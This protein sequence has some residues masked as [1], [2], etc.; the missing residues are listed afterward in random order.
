MNS[1]DSERVGAFFG[2]K[3]H[4][5]QRAIRSNVLCH[6]EMFATLDRVLADRVGNSNFRFADFGCGD[7]SAV[8]DV[9]RNKP[10]ARYIGVD[11]APDLIST[12]EKTLEVL[13]CEKTLICRDMAT[14]ICELDTLVD[15]I[16]CS[17]SLHH[18]FLDQK[19]TFIENCYRHLDTPG[20]FI[21]ID[22]IAA[23]KETREEWLD[24][25][26]RRILER[27]S[28]F[29]AEDRAQIMQHPRESDFPETIETFRRIAGKP[30]WRSF[31]VLLEKDHFLAFMLFEK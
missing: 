14:A 11:A 6:E 15:V 17:Y 25:L 4:L 23:E 8:V 20:Y 30:P 3:W 27:V 21:L 18:L 26:D 1:N 12:A 5:Y 24:R 7:S 2:D 29:T 22:G 10:V 16:L 9:L 28:D 13:D 31:E 19:I